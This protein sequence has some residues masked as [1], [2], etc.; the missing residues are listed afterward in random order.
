MGIKCTLKL[1]LKNLHFAHTM[2][3]RV[4][5]DSRINQLFFPQTALTGSPIY[6]AK[7]KYLNTRKFDYESQI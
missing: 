3:L 1:T 6:A 2:Y 5:H 7:I 4:S